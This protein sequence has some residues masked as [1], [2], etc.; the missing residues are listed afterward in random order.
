MNSTVAAATKPSTTNN[1]IK[2]S[3]GENIGTCK[4]GNDVRCGQ[5]NRG[6]YFP[7]VEPYV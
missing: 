5:S 7:A 2:R 6:R 3:T 4:D 1:K